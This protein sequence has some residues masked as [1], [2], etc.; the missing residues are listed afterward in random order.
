M[1]ILVIRQNRLQVKNCYKTQ[2]RTLYTDK[3]VNSPRLN[4]PQCTTQLKTELKLSNIPD[5]N[6]TDESTHILGDVTTPLSIIDRTSK[7]NQK[8][9]RKSK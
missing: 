4:N 2:R 1:T 7:H 6:E 5:R 3:R 9:Y 8:G